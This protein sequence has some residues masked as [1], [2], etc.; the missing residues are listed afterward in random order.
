MTI[1]ASSLLDGL[2]LGDGCLFRRAE[3]T[4]NGYLLRREARGSIYVQRQ[5]LDNMD[6]LH[7]IAQRLSS[8]GFESVVGVSWD[9]YA[10]LHTP[11][12]E[13]LNITRN[14]WYR[15]RTKIVPR[16]LI[17]DDVALANWFYGDGSVNQR[18][19]EITLS[20]HCFTE[21]EVDF[22]VCLLSMELEIEGKRRV[23]KGYPI[24]VIPSREGHKILKCCKSFPVESFNYKTERLRNEDHRRVYKWWSEKD[25][26]ALRLL[27]EER[28]APISE[29]SHQLS[30]N[31]RSTAA[32]ISRLMMTRQ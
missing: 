10:D 29:I 8:L 11:Q 25:V 18:N 1:Y 26:S 3:E 13:E 12:Y 32:Q 21:E 31:E 4:A 27:Y 15:E 9:G 16:D 19:G 14:R 30:R 22:L 2:L 23:D 7:K 20:T 6:W 28:G 24:I 5:H 17:L